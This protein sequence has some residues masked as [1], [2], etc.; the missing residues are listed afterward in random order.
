MSALL[1]FFVLFPLLLICIFF[2]FL[3]HPPSLMQQK[4]NMKCRIYISGPMTAM[5]DSNNWNRD[6]FYAAEEK[7]KAI[8]FETVNPHEINKNRDHAKERT[9]CL[10]AD[11]QALLDCTHIYLL[12]G[13]RRSQGACL[14]EHVARSL[15]LQIIYEC[16][17]C[18]WKE[19]LGQLILED[20]FRDTV[21]I[22]CAED[23]TLISQ[24]RSE[25]EIIF[26]ERECE[27][28]KQLPDVLARFRQSSP[29]S[30]GCLLKFK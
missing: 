2:S 7:F 20:L 16:A 24:T 21:C 3:L 30:L 27:I 15:K 29:G 1:F 6:A 17:I 18:Q 13:W 14:E 8:G 11:I 19:K 23:I 4:E 10:K 12:I 22:D 25:F 26:S 28:R 5:A 9:A